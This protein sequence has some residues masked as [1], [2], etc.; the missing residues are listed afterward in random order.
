MKIAF[1]NQPSDE[2][3]PPVSRG[4]L[5]IITAEIARRLARG[6]E[7]VVYARQGRGQAREETAGGLRVRR[8]PRVGLRAHQVLDALSAV[9]V[10]GARGAS[11]PFFAS[12][13]YFR[14]YLR[15]VLR[16]LPR[17]RPDVIHFFSL[18]QWA[19]LLR[20]ACP[21]A[22]LVLHM[23][24][25]S[26]S[27]L[28]ALRVAEH[29]RHVDL[30]VACSR[31]VADLV[32]RR[33]P[34]LGDRVRV[35][36]NGV[37]PE[38]FRPADD[39]A[40]EPGRILF[41]SRVSPEKG[42]HVLAEAFRKVWEERPD[43]RLDVVGAP[44]LLPWSFLLALSDDPNVRELARFY[45][46]GPLARAW[47]QLRRG[48]AYRA[49]LRRL[50]P[51]EAL[52]RVHFAGALPHEALPAR[53]QRASVFALPSLSEAFGIP[54]VEAMAC[55]LPVVGARSGGIAESVEHGT[56]G[57]LVAPGEAGELASAL[58]R[59]LDDPALAAAMGRSGRVRAV[60]LHSWD[61]VASEL[62][63][64]YRGLVQRGA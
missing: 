49:E 2:F 29:L 35:V 61:R 30:V 59:L 45:G 14:G 19:P 62:A 51:E 17:E 37:D 9:S 60:R 39:V 7:V 42:V 57:L 3:V 55:G 5:S 56:T 53:Y 31:H 4:S 43:A 36:P 41:V 48:E 40:P 22:R 27:Q 25:E 11:T 23:Q 10:L 34:G 52:H 58:L 24:G 28:P 64:L 46:S 50:L 32:C 21:D 18:S 6:H 47:R 33:L 1:L 8:I 20:A 13:R 16:D 26:L 38:R 54:V 12:P 63:D 44:G 15:R